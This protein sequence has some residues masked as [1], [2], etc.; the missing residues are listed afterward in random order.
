MDLVRDV[1]DLP[2]LDSD[3]NPVGRVD[4]IVAELGDDGRL[5][6]SALEISGAARAGR[7]HPALRDRAERLLERLRPAP[8]GSARIPWSDVERVGKSIRLRSRRAVEGP[9]AWERWLA[10]HVI[11]RIPGG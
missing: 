7:L 11:R 2:L 10:R 6:V 3:G 4:G 9:L 5:R 1:L 8:A